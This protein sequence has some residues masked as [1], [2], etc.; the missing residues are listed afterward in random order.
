MP[1]NPA[2]QG[3]AVSY[4]DRFGVHNQYYAPQVGLSAAAH[5][6][7]LSLDGTGKLGLGL[8]HQ[9]AKVDGGTTVRTADGSVSQFGGGVLAQP[10]NEGTHN[11]DRFAVIPEVT[12]TASY[13]LAPWCRATLGYNFLYASQVARAAS[14]IDGVD[15]RQVPQL[16]SYD[17]TAQAAA[18][19]FHFHDGSFWAQGLSA[20]L[21][22]RY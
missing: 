5:L 13:Q 11:G 15:S 19:A 21:E 18:P 2:P 14:L 4:F 17:P 6:G 7:R 22:F 10:G 1:S 12:L 3:N 20:G 8:L 9:S 16:R